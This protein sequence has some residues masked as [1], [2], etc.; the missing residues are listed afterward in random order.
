MRIGID[1]NALTGFNN[2]RTGVGR[3]VFELCRALDELIPEAEFFIY[4][5][6]PIE[7]PINSKRWV[8]RVDPLPGAKY[9][10]MWLKARGSLLCFNDN[11]DVFWGGASFLPYV[12]EK[13]RTVL[14]VHDL[15]YII[16]PET[17]M[18]RSFLAYKLFFANDV[19]KADCIITNSQGTC[20]RLRQQ[21]GVQAKSVV[22]PAVSTIFQ[23][24]EENDIKSCFRKYKIEFPY[25]LS[26]ATREPRKNL[27]LLVR[28]FLAMKQEGLLANYKLV[29]VGP[30][31]WKSKHLL[32]LLQKQDEI[33]SLGYVS[34]DDLICLYSGA[35][36]FVFPSKYEGLG[37]PVL[38]ARAC[39]TPVIAS[40]L[41]EIREVG[42]NDTIYISPQE[43][44]LRQAFL[45][46]TNKT[47][48]SVFQTS[49][50]FSWYS[51]K[52]SATL[53]ARALVGE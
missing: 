41:P 49:K 53:L 17:M 12:R 39:G 34:D 5:K 37:M 15:N 13:V 42:G 44:N 35:Q 1:G 31:G 30:G 32:R 22:Y 3:Y 23:R 18:M 10:W 2:Q 27:D 19:K 8:L 4:S 52:D 11:L 40:D 38:E 50:E 6:T 28:T 47:D 16:A 14:T 7:V 48:E 21:F 46:F 36:A 43:D 24:K 51:W 45:T 26:V 33:L 9:V 20:E 25:F 29:L